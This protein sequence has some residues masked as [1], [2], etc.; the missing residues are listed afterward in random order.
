MGDGISALPDPARALGL[1]PKR[2]SEDR[3]HSPV[4]DPVHLSMHNEDRAQGSLLAHNLF[5]GSFF[6]ASCRLRG[7]S[8][9]R[10]L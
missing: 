6:E 3:P 7:K 5:G 10:C 9:G 4:A 1:G 2:S 8:T